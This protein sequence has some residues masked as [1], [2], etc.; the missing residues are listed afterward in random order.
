MNFRRHAIDQPMPFAPHAIEVFHTTRRR[1]RVMHWL[2]V[3]LAVADLVLVAVLV[4][5]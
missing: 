3:G 1:R 5:G 4:F 2:I